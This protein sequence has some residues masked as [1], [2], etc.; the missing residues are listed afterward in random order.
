MPNVGTRLPPPVSHTS[1]HQWQSF[2]G[3]MRYRR[4]ERCVLRAQTA[5]EAGMEE[6][7]RAALAEARALNADTP[8]L[9]SMR[10]AVLQRRALAIASSR[11]ARA[12]RAAVLALSAMVVLVAAVAMWP[13][14]DNITETIPVSAQAAQPSH[15]AAQTA[16][17]SPPT[18]TAQPVTAQSVSAPPFAPPLSSA[19]TKAGSS[20]PPESSAP[21]ESATARSAETNPPPDPLPVVNTMAMSSVTPETRQPSIEKTDPQVPLAPS[22]TETTTVA[23]APPSSSGTGRLVGDL[24]AATMAI[25][26]TPPPPPP[27]APAPDPRTLDEPQVRAV[28]AQFEAA[29][30]NLSADAAQAV[31]PGVDQ[32]SLARAF[33]SLESQ[34]VMLG[35]CSIEI[36]GATASAECSGTTSWTPKV[37]G[38][39]HTEPRRW[40]FDFAKTDGAWRIERAQAR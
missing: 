8:D 6:D 40:Q 28:L 7:A 22:T 13:S 31:W 17:P 4:A 36:S 2:E 20:A 11:R 24:P 9:E 21:R 12:R 38:G 18:P 14:T 34:R 29:Y 32:R 30:N 10:A 16:Q 19:E 23:V 39:R 33:A 3:R 25:P 26:R 37:G 15:V 5:L 27:P 1:T 35:R